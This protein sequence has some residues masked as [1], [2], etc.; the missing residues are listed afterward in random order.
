MA[1]D[2]YTGTLHQA[3]IVAQFLVGMKTLDEAI[4]A[5][6]LAETTGPIL[7]PTLYRQK[8]RALSQDLQ[9]MR[10]LR[11]CRNELIKAGVRTG[12]QS[13]Q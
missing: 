7:D 3:H 8:R 13:C 12:E 10:I 11:N 6:D 2:T 9:V 5:A 4:Q 1:E